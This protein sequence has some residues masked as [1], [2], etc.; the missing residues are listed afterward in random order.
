MHPAPG[1]ARKEILFTRK[2]RTLYA[3]LPRRPTG[4]FTVRD[5]RLARGARI[6]LLGSGHANIAWRQKGADVVIATPAIGDGEMP[7]EGPLV[8]VLQMP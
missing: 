1:D 8:F 3:I 2:G 5:L 6:S 7:F 4:D